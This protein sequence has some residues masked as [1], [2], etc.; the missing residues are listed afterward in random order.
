MHIE[1][2]EGLLLASLAVTYG[3][4]TKQ[5]ERMA[6]DTGATHTIIASDAVGDI[7]IFLQ[8]GDHINRSYE[9]A[10][11]ITHLKKLLIVLNLADF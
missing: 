9:L 6:I 4:R 7:G 3:G 8:M 1:Y 11:L 5:I 2:L 10:V